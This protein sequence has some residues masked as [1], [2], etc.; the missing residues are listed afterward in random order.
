MGAFHRVLPGSVAAD[1]EAAVA[2]CSP[3]QTRQQ[4]QL[5]QLQ[6][7]AQQQ[8]LTARDAGQS[9]ARRDAAWPKV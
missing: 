9:F 3:L 6:S 1:F 7:S 5:V 2:A 4:L 8:Y